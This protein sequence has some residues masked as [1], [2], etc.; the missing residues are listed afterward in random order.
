MNEKESKQIL[1]YISE[2]KECTIEELSAFF[3]VSQSTMRRELNKLQEKNLVSRTHGGVILND[4]NLKSPNF[5]FRSHQNSFEKKK[6]ALKALSLIH[7]G[8]LIFL[9]SSSSAFYVGEYLSNFSNISVITN[10]IDTLNIL[11]KM[12]ITSYSTGG[13]VSIYNKSSLVGRYA[14]KFIDGFH[15]DICFFSV[16]SLDEN[17]IMYDCYEEENY[18]RKKMME[19]AKIKVLLL[20]KT[21]I[22]RT[23]QYKL[24]S[25]ENID[26]IVS[27][28][29]LSKIIKINK[30]KVIF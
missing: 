24:E 20:D 26:Y 3:N 9:D 2:K 28:I 22:N 10:G 27:D 7:N 11:S 21:K 25:V 15:A 1:D 14:E 6:I 19:N 16:Q 8:D 18:L 30:E 12:N 5:H 13:K 4:E 23:S 17:G 29:D